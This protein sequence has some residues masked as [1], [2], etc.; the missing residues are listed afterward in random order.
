MG[1]I[2]GGIYF[3]RIGEFC[4]SERFIMWDYFDWWTIFDKKQEYISD[5][6]IPYV[7]A[8][9]LVPMSEEQV[10]DLLNNLN[11]ENNELKKETVQLKQRIKILEDTIDWLTGTI[12]FFELEER[13]WVK[14][15]WFHIKRGTYI[16]VRLLYKKIHSNFYKYWLPWLLWRVWKNTRWYF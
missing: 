6:N 7:D 11:D 3:I 10:V 5:H 14:N 12:A 13:M 1:R 4:M 8:D 16:T 2:V 15:G 9:N